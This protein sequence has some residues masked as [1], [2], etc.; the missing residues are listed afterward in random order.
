METMVLMGSEDVSRAAGQM[1]EAA[2]EMNRAAGS[3][4]FA[5]RQHENFMNDWLSRFEA[6]IERMHQ[7]E[8]K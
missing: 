3:I 6:A 7:T 5:L 8:G 2:S 1:R 4:E